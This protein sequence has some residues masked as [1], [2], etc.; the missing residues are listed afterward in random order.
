MKVSQSEPSGNLVPNLINWFIF[1]IVAGI[2][3]QFNA[4]FTLIGTP[5][6][7]YDILMGLELLPPAVVSAE[8]EFN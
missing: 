1:N 3:F 4:L 7:G 8:L 6:W 5:G 2:C